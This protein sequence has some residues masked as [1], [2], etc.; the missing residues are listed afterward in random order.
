MS[1]AL[2]CSCREALRVMALGTLLVDFCMRRSVLP[3]AESVQN[4]LELRA[5]ERLRRLGMWIVPLIE[6]KLLQAR[7][8]HFAGNSPRLGATVA[9][10]RITRLAAN[11]RRIPGCGDG[12]SHRVRSNAQQR[13]PSPLPIICVHL[14]HLRMLP[15][16]GKDRKSVV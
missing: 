11:E 7:A 16:S 2:S 10:D 1:T 3:L 9:T 14:C 4:R 12:K 6:H 8:P 5:R 15:V 13:K